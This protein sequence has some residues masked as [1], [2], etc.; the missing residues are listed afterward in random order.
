MKV[1]RDLSGQDLARL[2]YQASRQTGSH[3]RPT[4][5]TPTVHSVT[6]PAHSPLKIGTLSW[7]LKDIGTHVGNDRE[8]LLK[9]LFA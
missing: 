7:I 8:E 5:K 2:G 4:T 3:I 6:V 9:T 1:R